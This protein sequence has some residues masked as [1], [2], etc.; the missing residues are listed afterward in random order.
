MIVVDFN[1]ITDPDEKRGGKIHDITRILPFINCS[2]DCGMIDL[3]YNGSPYT[4]CNG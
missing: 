2:G 3:G 1:Y 4:W